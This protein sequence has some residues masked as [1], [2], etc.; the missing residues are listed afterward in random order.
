MSNK[1]LF[2]ARNSWAL[3]TCPKPYPASSAIPKWWKDQ[4]PYL[5]TEKD[6]TGKTLYLENRVT[7][8]TFKKCTPMLDT[9]TAGYIVPLFADVLITQ[10][11]SGPG[12]AWKIVGGEPFVEHHVTSVD[13]E[14]PSE[15]GKSTMKYNS[16]WTIKT[17]PGYSCLIVHPYGYRNSPLRAVEGILDTDRYVL[18]ISIPVWIRKDFEGVIEKGTPICQVIPFKREEWKADFDSYEDNKYEKILDKTLGSTIIN[19]YVK[20]FWSKKSYK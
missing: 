18:D 8:S 5:P 13:V 6:P 11:P 17:P 4:P 2:R 7:N 14:R 15:F 19:H 1:I 16:Y 9:L 20:H 12:I 10:Y 3:E